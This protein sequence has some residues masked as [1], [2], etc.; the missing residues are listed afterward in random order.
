MAAG[1][2]L[3]LASHA[4]HVDESASTMLLL[5]GLAVGVDYSLFYIRR[6]ARGARGRAVHARGDRH[7]RRHVG[8]VRA[9]VRAHRDR[10]DGRDVPHRPAH[11]H[12][13]GRG[14]DPRGRRRRP[15]LADGP[16]RDARR[17][18][19]TASRRAASRG[20]AGGCRPGATAGPAARWTWVLDRVLARPGRERAH[21]LR[22]SDRA[23][24]PGAQPAHLGAEP[25]AGA[26]ARPADHEDLPA[27]AA[28]VPRR[29]AAGQRGGVRAPTSRARA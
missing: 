17:S 5:I 15:R 6:A 9:R 14:H 2:L 20:S 12:G 22:A 27:H 19:A 3:A 18:S 21:R 13:H 11:V 24:R 1:G 25:V 16:A 4:L 8:A 26:A 10:R 23:G 29:A 28:G 7:R